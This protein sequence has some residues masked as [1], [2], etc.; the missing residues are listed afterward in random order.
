MSL[1]IDVPVG[2]W[3]SMVAAMTE[4]RLLLQEAAHR[5]ANELAAAIAALRLIRPAN[6]SRLRWRLLQGALER[7]E[8]FAAVNRVLALPTG[9]PVALSVELGRLC[10]GLGEARRAI[11]GSEIKL[12]LREIVA[13]GVTARRVLMVAAELVHNGIRH[14]LEGRTGNLKVVLR[15]D[16]ETVM[17]SV[18]D[19]GPGMTAAAGTA[20]NGMGGFIVAELVRR[21]GGVIDCST[22]P[23]GTAFYVGIPHLVPV[24]ADDD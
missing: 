9:A 6:G 12:D 11:G 15:L 2:G 10:K 20:G 21:A 16:D 18:I 22:G 5:T 7:L 8:G 17:L 19:D 14:A 4:D 1:G 23:D 3:D 13:D 24:D